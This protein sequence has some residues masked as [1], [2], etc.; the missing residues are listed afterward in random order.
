RSDVAGGGAAEVVD[1][2]CPA[3]E[4]L[5]RGGHQVQVGAQPLHLVG[6][7]D[8]RPHGVGDRVPGGLVAGDDQQQEVVVEVAV[9]QRFAVVRRLVDELADQVGAASAAPLGGQFP[10]VLEHLPG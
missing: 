3:Q 2:R 8:E 7:L 9:G 4:L 10:A 5:H 1:R 6:V